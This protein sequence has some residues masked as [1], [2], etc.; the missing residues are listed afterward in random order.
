MASESQAR[1]A[2]FIREQRLAWRKANAA[3]LSAAVRER[4]AARKSRIFAAY[5]GKCACCLESRIEFLTLDHIN[6][7]GKTHRKQVGRSNVYRDVEKRGY[8]ATFRLLCFNCNCSRGIHGYCPHE[9]TPGPASP[10]G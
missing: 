2:P 9:S 10:R 3:R 4:A 5:G 8:P 6:G 1:R 7:D